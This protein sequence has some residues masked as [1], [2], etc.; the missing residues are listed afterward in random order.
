MTENSKL[1]ATTITFYINVSVR[2]RSSFETSWTEY[3]ENNY[4]MPHFYNA[5]RPAFDII[6]GD[7]GQEIYDFVIEEFR[8]NIRTEGE[9]INDLKTNIERVKIFRENDDILGQ[10]FWTTY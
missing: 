9:S 10:L 7:N 5:Y 8:E 1:M 3:E 4:V 2:L 6:Y